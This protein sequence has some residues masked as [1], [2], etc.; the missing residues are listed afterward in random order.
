M[1]VTLAGATPGLMACLA[2]RP[3]ERK[4]AAHKR[5]G[6]DAA[7]AVPTPRQAAIAAIALKT[8]AA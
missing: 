1:E 3:F 7:R 2:D 4:T 8:G 5:P 6:R